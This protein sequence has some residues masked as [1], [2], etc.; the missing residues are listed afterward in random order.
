MW[1]IDKRLADVGCRTGRSISI[2]I[3]CDGTPSLSVRLEST[4]LKISASRSDSPTVGAITRS[5]KR[6]MAKMGLFIRK[7][8]SFFPV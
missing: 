2:D 3:Y 4:P 6:K 7:V 8:Q 1:I 5:F